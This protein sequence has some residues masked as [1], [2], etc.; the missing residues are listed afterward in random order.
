MIF[1]PTQSFPLLIRGSS[2]FLLIAQV[3]DPFTLYIETSEDEYCQYLS[4]GDIIAVSA[5]EGGELRQAE[6]L[7][8]LILRWHTPLVVLPR[9]HPGSDKLKMVVSAGDQIHM[10]C[11]IQRGTH[12]EQTVLCSAEEF[13][14]MTISGT[15][16]GIEIT[17]MPE[18]VTHIWLT[19]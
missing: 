12:P 10:S 3:Q 19:N 7:L 14:G 11:S 15:E 17:G 8:E 1:F 18:S 16:Q 4:S 9:G 6:I 13:A 2:S 5:P